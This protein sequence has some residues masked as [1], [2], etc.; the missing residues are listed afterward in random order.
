MS[1]TKL[2]SVEKGSIARAISPTF[3]THVNPVSSR[4]PAGKTDYIREQRIAAGCSLFND[5][6]D[7]GLFWPPWAQA[8][9]AQ[10]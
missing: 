6:P 4:E 3:A 7:N 1:G 8:L 10:G 5:S 9:I 2:C